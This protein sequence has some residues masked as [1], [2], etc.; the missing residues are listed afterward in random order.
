MP[1]QKQASA[2]IAKQDRP[3]ILEPLR[4]Q[5]VRL[6]HTRQTGRAA[7]NA[8]QAENLWQRQQIAQFAPQEGPLEPGASRVFSA[9]PGNSHQRKAQFVHL[10]LKDDL[11]KRLQQ[12]A[13]CAQLARSLQRQPQYV[14]SVQRDPFR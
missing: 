6:E 9:M 3:P 5:I 4:A 1:V 14:V 13:V 12:N 10:V 11:Q 8:P 2:Q 7:F